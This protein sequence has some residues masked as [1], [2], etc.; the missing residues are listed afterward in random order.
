VV[1]RP[2]TVV[3]VVRKMVE[4]VNPARV[5]VLAKGNVVLVVV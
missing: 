2:I 4:E 5:V 3:V 1:V